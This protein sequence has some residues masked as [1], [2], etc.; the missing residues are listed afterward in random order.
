MDTDCLSRYEQSNNLLKTEQF[1]HQNKY[2]QHN[3]KAPTI[4]LLY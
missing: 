3:L 1:Q 2:L 4:Q